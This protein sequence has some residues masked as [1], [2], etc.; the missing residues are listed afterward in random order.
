MGILNFNGHPRIDFLINIYKAIKLNTFVEKQAAE[1]AETGV[2]QEEGQKPVYFATSIGITFAD[3]NSIANNPAILNA[4]EGAPEEAISKENGFTTFKVVTQ[5]LG[6][7][8]HLAYCYAAEGKVVRA[9]F[10]GITPFQAEDEDGVMQN[11]NVQLIS[12]SEVT[13]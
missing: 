3:D 4:L 12:I 13:A 8:L 7:F 6:Y 10:D 9:D 5:D 2:Q 11:F 1:V